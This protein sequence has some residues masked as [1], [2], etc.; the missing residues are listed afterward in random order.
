MGNKRYAKEWL[1]LGYAH[2]NTANFLFENNY[3]E[4]IIG[5]ELQQA[6]EKFIK[7][8]IADQ[9]R[10]I[11][12]DHDLVKLSYLIEEFISINDDEL[13]LL[14]LASDYFIHTRYPNPNYQLP[15]KDDIYKVLEFCKTFFV[16]VCKTLDIEPS[17][18]TDVR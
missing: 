14:R 4:N 10:K 3:Y 9:N 15:S 16:E 12:K 18:V 1:E 8:I 5:I 7:S 11:P 2:L 17:E 13:V 6:F